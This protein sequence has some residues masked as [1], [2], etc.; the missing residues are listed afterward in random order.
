MSDLTK[1]YT[2]YLKPLKSTDKNRARRVFLEPGRYHGLDSISAAAG[3]GDINLEVTH[4]ELSTVTIDDNSEITVGGLITKHGLVA[5]V[6]LP[7]PIS[8][9]F[10][11]TGETQF[12]VFY[13]E[14]PW[15][16]SD[17]DNPIIFGAYAQVNVEPIVAPTLSAIQ[18][19][20]GYF[21]IADG[22]SDITGVSYTPYPKPN[23]AGQPDLD[24]SGYATLAEENN[25]T[26]L[27]VFSETNVDSSTLN[28]LGQDSYEL[29][30][31]VNTNIVHIEAL[32]GFPSRLTIDEIKFV[33]GRTPKDGEIL[34]FYFAPCSVSVW[35]NSSVFVIGSNA[36]EM[37]L[38]NGASIA[39]VRSH[40]KYV[41]FAAS[42]GLDKAITTLKGRVSALEVVATDWVDFVEPGYVVDDVT[43]DYLQTLIKGGFVYVRMQLS[44][45]ATIA[46]GTAITLDTKSIG[47][48][49]LPVYQHSLVGQSDTPL[50]LNSVSSGNT[51]MKNIDEISA[52]N[53][54]VLPPTI[55][56]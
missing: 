19:P 13:A 51:H 16:S 39:F 43:V 20:L 28:E 8:V 37:S 45:G 21:T 38:A 53:V 50:F 32:G 3:A 27:N 49:R 26:G 40:S 7:I 54:F 2:E 15:V 24:L 36:K 52:G 56:I 14:H 5:E 22:A 9:S 11:A 25:F 41:A 10:N 6:L 33:G 17:A 55:I 29:V 4:S 18:V 34:V 1:R 31:P 30:I 12:Q 35:W 44:I 47:A 42:S 48:V 46:A 23:L